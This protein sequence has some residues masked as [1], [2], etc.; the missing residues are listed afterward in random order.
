MKKSVKKIMTI[1]LCICIITVGSG[2]AYAQSSETIE[3][4]ADRLITVSIEE[5]DDYTNKSY[6]NI[7]A[8]V[9]AVK[10]QLPDIS[11]AEIGGFLIEYTGQGSPEDLTEEILV[12]T[13]EF[14]EITVQEEFIKESA[15]GTTSTVSKSEVSRAMIAEFNT[16]S[17][18]PKA[19][20]TSSDGYMKIT[21]T[22]SFWSNTGT[23]DYYIITTLAEWLKAPVNRFKD[24]ICISNT[25]TYDDSYTDYAYYKQSFSCY[26]SSGTVH[27]TENISDERF[28]DQSNSKIDFIYPSVNGAGARVDLRTFVC[29]IGHS[30]KYNYMK[31]FIRYRIICKS[32][33]TYNIQGAYCHAKVGIGSVGFSVSTGGAGISFSFAGTKSEYFAKPV[34]IDAV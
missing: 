20:W 32:G 18:S 24:V 23:N 29:G 9:S 7:S 14:K 3:E 28:S 25:A 26:N 8:F 27:L 31:A 16:P 11:D 2:N 33:N 12:E 10:E 22:Y 4:I 1:V 21:T 5:C 15:D 17:I 19:T 34:T 6:K 13:A 30:V